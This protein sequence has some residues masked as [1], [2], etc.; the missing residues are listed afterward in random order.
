MIEQ[1][2]YYPAV[3]VIFENCLIFSNAHHLSNHTWSNIGWFAI[4]RSR[5]FIFNPQSIS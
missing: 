1:L 2:V 5:A 3:Y 4:S